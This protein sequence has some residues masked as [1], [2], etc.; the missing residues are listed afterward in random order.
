M[1]KASA[2]LLVLSLLLFAG[3]PAQAAERGRMVKMTFEFVDACDDGY[4]P[5][6]D[7]YL[8]E[9]PSRYWGTF[10][11]K[12]YNEPLSTTLSCEAG[13]EICFGSW[14]KN[15]SW[16]CGKK[17]SEPTKGACFVCQEATVSIGLQC[18]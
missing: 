11:L 4:S 10:W 9:N 13:K 17:C 15:A 14:L 7:F 6:I 12:Y 2:L 8:K 1:G 16:G 5:E 3:T 18:Q